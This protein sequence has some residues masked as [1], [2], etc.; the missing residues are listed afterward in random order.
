[1]N[2]D[3]NGKTDILDVTLTFYGGNHRFASGVGHWLM[4]RSWRQKLVRRHVVLQRRPWGMRTSSV[5]W[6]SP[7]HPSYRPTGW[8]L[9]HTS[10]VSYIY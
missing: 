2:N 6:R 5:R 4:R 8:N 7:P 9:A 1:M 10:M 3:S